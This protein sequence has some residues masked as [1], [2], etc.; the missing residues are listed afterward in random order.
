MAAVVEV[1][2]G[3]ALRGRAGCIEDDIEEG[4][5]NVRSVREEQLTELTEAW[6]K[7]HEEWAN[8]RD[9]YSPSKGIYDSIGVAADVG[10]NRAKTHE[11]EQ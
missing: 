2:S 8:N 3:A 11:G 5:K 7:S 6:Y 4:N 10:N 1:V 9:G